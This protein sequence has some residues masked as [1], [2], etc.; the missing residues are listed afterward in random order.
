MIFETN[1]SIAVVNTTGKY[2][3]KD[4]SIFD[5]NKINE[6]F[7]SLKVNF[8]NNKVLLLKIKCGLC[9]N[10]HYY[11]CDINKLIKK[12]IIIKGCEL[13][14]IPILYMGNRKSIEEKILKYSQVNKKIYAMI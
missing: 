9:G 5:T 11:K 8:I 2:C 7:T 10:I 14:G 12:S 1:I 3:I 4:F 6:S 13:L